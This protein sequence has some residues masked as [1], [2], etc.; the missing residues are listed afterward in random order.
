MPSWRQVSTAST[1]MPTADWTDVHSFVPS[2]SLWGHGTHWGPACVCVAVCATLLGM[3]TKWVAVALPA[4]RS[5]LLSVLPRCDAQ[6][7]LKK[8]VRG[9]RRADH[10]YAT[11]YCTWNGEQADR[12]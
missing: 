4:P 11:A 12:L 8:R 2:F 7:L 9:E 10:L 6:G 3:A 5:S 1:N